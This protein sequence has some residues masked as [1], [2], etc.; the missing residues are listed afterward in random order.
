MQTPNSTSYFINGKFQNGDIFYSPY[1]LTFIFV[2]L[3]IYADSTFY[4]QYLMADEP[5]LPPTAPGAGSSSSDYVEALLKYPW[6]ESQIL[7]KAQPGPTGRYV[8]S[9]GIQQGYY[10]DSD[11]TNGGKDMLLTWTVPT[12]ANPAALDSEYQFVTAH[13]KFA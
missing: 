5:I 3:T 12:G 6:S 2:Y 10:G 8:Y 4:Y 1:H 7:Y 9:G 13:L 11:I